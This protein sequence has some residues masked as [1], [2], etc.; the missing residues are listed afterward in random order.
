MK[1]HI[2]RNYPK[3][4]LLEKESRIADYQCSLIRVPTRETEAQSYSLFIVDSFECK[5]V[6]L[7]PT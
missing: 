7:R 5:G 2:A 4:D 1:C 6:I 3:K